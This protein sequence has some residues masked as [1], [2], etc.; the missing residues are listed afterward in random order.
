ME[1]TNK[2]QKSMKHRIIKI[3][4]AAAIMVTTGVAAMLLGAFGNANQ[5]L[6]RL[7]TDGYT[8]LKL[9]VMVAFLIA[10]LEVIR[11]ILESVT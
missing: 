10:I 7:Q 9:T 6:G 2:K 8:I 3:I 1:D 11:L 4:I 5:I